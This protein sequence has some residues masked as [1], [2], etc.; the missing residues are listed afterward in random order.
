M[1]G[2]IAETPAAA[3]AHALALLG[4]ADL[5]RRMG[6]AARETARRLFS[7]AAWR[8]GALDAIARAGKKYRRR[9]RAVATR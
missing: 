1:D 8:A 5:A 7:P 4:D 2:F 9:Q 6:D 3:R